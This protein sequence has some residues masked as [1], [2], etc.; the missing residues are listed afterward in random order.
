MV[1]A[2][3][4]NGKKPNNLGGGFGAWNKDP[5]D[6]TQGC[7]DSFYTDKEKGD[8]S[9]KLTYDVDSPNPAYCGFWMQ[10]QDEDA[11]DMEELVLSARGDDTAGYT[12]QVKLE[13]KNAK[14]E[15]GRYLLEGIT[16]EWQEFRIPLSEFS[17][18][19]DLSDMKEF[20]IVFDDTNS[21]VKEGVIYLDD[22]A[23]E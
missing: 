18:I 5:N 11:S 10:L 6:T 22:V 15:V 21:L 12:S 8:I 2:D 3:F 7:K 19:T 23:I 17:G 20:V 4:N 9:L 1:V 16:E 14:G 13:L